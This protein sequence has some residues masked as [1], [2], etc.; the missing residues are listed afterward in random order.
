M[1]VAAVANVMDPALV[2]DILRQHN[3][4]FPFLDLMAALR[5]QGLTDAAARDLIWRL[6]AHG[7]IVFT[8]GR[9]RLRFAENRKVAG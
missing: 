7:T 2:T 3:G 9:D 6:L 8:S 5:N 4:E 1:S